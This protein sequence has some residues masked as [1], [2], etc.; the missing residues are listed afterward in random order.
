VVIELVYRD[1]RQKGVGLEP[2]TG[3]K[4]PQPVIEMWTLLSNSSQPD[5]KYCQCAEEGFFVP[6]QE[7]AYPLRRA[8]DRRVVNVFWR[9]ECVPNLPKVAA[10]ICSTYASGK[11]CAIAEQ[12]SLKFMHYD[13]GDEP[14]GIDFLP[15]LSSYVIRQSFLYTQCLLECFRAGCFRAARPSAITLL[16]QT[17]KVHHSGG[18]ASDI[19]SEVADYIP[20]D[21]RPRADTSAALTQAGITHDTGAD[22]LIADSDKVVSKNLIYEAFLGL[23]PQREPTSVT[24]LLRDRPTGKFV[25]LPELPEAVVREPVSQLLKLKPLDMCPATHA[26]GHQ[27]IRWIEVVQQQR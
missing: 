1:G 3:L 12:H 16:G 14:G 2:H 6:W 21:R 17:V 9:S 20:S 25:F 27:H 13:E 18:C 7:I 10:Q 22:R 19:I 23:A 26:V 4:P 8:G 11:S 5:L 24:W 15:D